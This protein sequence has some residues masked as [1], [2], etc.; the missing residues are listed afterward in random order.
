MMVNI[1][2]IKISFDMLILKIGIVDITL[3][4]V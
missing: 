1:N 2:Y 4:N 3:L